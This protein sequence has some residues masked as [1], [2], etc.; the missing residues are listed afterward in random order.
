MFK[1]NYFMYITNTYITVAHIIIF[2]FNL[3]YVNNKINEQS[4]K[5]AIY[6]YLHFIN[7]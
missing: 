3:Y 1:L 4:M 2:H 5:T 6:F 7:A